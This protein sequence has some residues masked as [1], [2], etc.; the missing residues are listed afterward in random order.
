MPMPRA[1][2]G[3]DCDLVSVGPIDRTGRHFRWRVEVTQKTKDVLSRS[4]RHRQLVTSCARYV[5]PGRRVRCIGVLLLHMRA[6]EAQ[7]VGAP[8][9][10]RIP[11]AE[12]E[13][14][15]AP[16]SSGLVRNGMQVPLSQL[17]RARTVH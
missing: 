11:R 9:A 13:P 1:V 17:M 16:T 4:A 2:G 8:L 12:R 3:N 14:G 10:K 6:L 5:I 7:W 15:S